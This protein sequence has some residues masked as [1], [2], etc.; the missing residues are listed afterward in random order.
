MEKKLRTTRTL[1]QFVALS[2][3][4]HLI[5][6]PHM[7]LGSFQHDTRNEWIYLPETKK[8][9]YSSI[10]LSDAMIRVFLEI[11]SNA[12]DNVISS[13]NMGVSPGAIYMTMDSKRISIKNE[14]EPLVLEMTKQVKPSVILPQMLFGVM[15]T[16]NTFSNED[17]ES[18]NTISCHGVGAKGT[19]IMSKEFIV[20]AGDNKRGQ[21]CRIIWKDNMVLS[22]CDVSPGYQLDSKG[23]Y[24]IKPGKK[25]TG[26][27]YV[28][29]EFELDFEK[30]GYTE[31]PTEAFYLFQRYLIDTGFINKIPV[32]FNGE[33][34]EVHNIKDYSKL[35]FDEIHNSIIHHEW[36][37]PLTEEEKKAYKKNKD[38][39]IASKPPDV[40]LI[41]V[42][43]PNNGCKIGFVNGLTVPE[44]NHIEACYTS[45]LS[46]IL[47]KINGKPEKKKKDKEEKKKI[48]LTMLDIKSHV[49]LIISVRVLDPAFSSQSKE[50]LTR[51]KIALNIDSSLIKKIDGWSLTECLYA[52]LDAK[53]YKN[54]KKTDGKSKRYI[55]ATKG[56]D[57][58]ASGGSES[59]K[60]ILYLCEGDS[61][62]GYIKK[63][64]GM[65]PDKKLYAGYIPL[66]GK[67]INVSSCSY[68]QMSAN[69]EIAEIKSYLGLREGVDYKDP[70][71]KAELRYGSVVLACD[72]DSDGK[73]INALLINFFHARFPSLIESYMISYL[74]TPVIR[75]NEVGGGVTR[76]YN[77]EEFNRSVIGESGK[78]KHIKMIEDGKEV[79]KKGIPIHLKG[80]GSSE[81]DE[82]LDDLNTAPIV[83]CYYDDNS[84]ET[85]NL[86][87]NPKLADCRKEWIEKCRYLHFSTNFE[88]ISEENNL[89]RKRG[90]TPIINE[91]LVEYCVEALR[92][93]IGSCHDGLK[94]SQRKTIYA[95]LEKYNY[96]KSKGEPTKVNKMASD[97]STKTSYI[98]G[99][100]SLEEV[101]VK[102]GQDFI[103]ACNLPFFNI[104]GQG[105]TRDE[106]DDRA[107]SRYI[108][109]SLSKWVEHAFC[110]ELISLIPMNIVEGE[111]SEPEFIPCD[112]PLHAAF[113]LKGIA[114]GWSC[115]FLP[116][117]V[118]EVID[119]ILDRNS[120]KEPKILTPWFKGFKGKVYFAEKKS[121]IL[122]KGKEEIDDEA[123][124]TEEKEEIVDVKGK[125]SLITE[126]LFEFKKVGDKYDIKITEIPIGRYI[127]DYRTWLEELRKEKLIKSFDDKCDWSNINYEIKGCSFMPTA[128]SLFLRKTFGMSN[129]TFIDEKAIPRK[130]K[131]IRD[132]L[133][134]YWNKMIA[135]Y[136]QL[137]DKRVSDA[138]IK[139]LDLEDKYKFIDLVAVKQAF[140][141]MKRKKADIQEDM[142][143]NNINTKHLDEL[144]ASSFCVEELESI[145]NKINEE[146]ERLKQISSSTPQQLWSERLVKLRKV[147]L[148]YEV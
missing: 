100:V 136:K 34:F 55:D 45:L 54:L 50:K 12:G 132:V 32:Y 58:G 93:C 61:A 42:D 103:G 11:L 84:R 91:D 46:P 127:H 78:T 115:N 21:E 10:T 35:Y 22:S 121:K 49:S 3:R 97:V 57:A 83:I 130:Y 64:I 6:R 39:F 98:H 111:E 47:E 65:S 27:N 147:V 26:E 131:T 95:A 96:G 88:R 118:S 41:L 20:E 36:I 113:G 141:I 89:I 63:R 105:G 38:K 143:K 119:W 9:Q 25:Y 43:T 142:I 33:K 114:T 107:S 101:I 77:P 69:T 140:S 110:K 137:I 18:R 16:S 123:L 122:I 138:K 108:K 53:N 112:I 129:M 4:S 75:F 60:C 13:R 40:E 117:K 82:I 66:K 59:E 52:V 126:G 79:I 70:I 124:P 1:D 125:I 37:T 86:A 8:Y 109:V 31:W 14:G 94:E 71:N 51:P 144:K 145:R 44:G 133:D 102:L 76:F 67:F 99:E 80:L 134:V 28:K 120:N 73:C 19:C 104:H 146:I 68:E 87:F 30:F 2:P 17:T 128:K 72:A 23:E 85:L 29:V 7:Y 92:R 48:N 139:I 135:T 81:D 90:I 5:K 15:L 116:L 106:K 56:E 24:V 62:S 74:M 148:T